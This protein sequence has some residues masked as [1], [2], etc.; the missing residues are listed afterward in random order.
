MLILRLQDGKWRNGKII[1]I[2][3]F[4]NYITGKVKKFIIII[5]WI[6]TEPAAILSNY[7]IIKRIGSKLK[8]EQKILYFIDKFYVT[9]KNLEI[10]G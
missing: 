3:N 6:T 10:R 8:T 4:G 5:I 1:I 2:V 7:C 9:L